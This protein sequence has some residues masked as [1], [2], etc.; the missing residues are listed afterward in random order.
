MVSPVRVGGIHVCFSSR[1][2][3]LLSCYLFSVLSPK[4]EAASERPASCLAIP[5]VVE[6]REIRV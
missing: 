1:F 2:V 5:Y 4:F 3:V 6:D